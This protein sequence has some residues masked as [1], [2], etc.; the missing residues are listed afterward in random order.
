MWSLN[1]DNLPPL[2]RAAQDRHAAPPALVQRQA[3][4]GRGVALQRRHALHGRV[5]VH[6]HAITDALEEEQAVAAERDLAG[7]RLRR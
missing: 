7:M 6:L 1:K 2:R 3:E 4:R 5:G